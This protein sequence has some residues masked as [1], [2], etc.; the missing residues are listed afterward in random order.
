MKM[1]NM[2]GLSGNF[3]SVFQSLRRNG[4][5]LAIALGSLI[6]SPSAAMGQQVDFAIRQQFLSDPLTTEPRDPLLPNPPI[7]RPLS[8]LE[9]YELENQLDDLDQQSQ[10]LLAVGETN[11]AFV[12]WIRELRLRRALGEAQEMMAL[13]RVGALAW[14]NQRTRETQLI[15]LRLRQIQAE[16][17]AQ[18]PIEAQKLE[19]LADLFLVLRAQDSALEIYQ[20]LLSFA[21]Q[22]GDIAAQAA[23][24]TRIGEIHLAWFEFAAASETY[25]QLLAIARAEAEPVLEEEA[26]KRLISAFQQGEQPTQA[27]PYQQELIKFYQV[28]GT[29]DPIP[30]LEFALA[31]NYQADNRPD[32]A[33][34]HYQAAY[35]AA[36]RLQQYGYS[37]DVLWRLADLYRSLNRPEDTLY[38]LQ[39]LVEVEKQSYN[40]Y[41]IMNV[42][43]QI[44]QIYKGQGE[45]EQAIDALREGLILAR[46]LNYRQAYFEEQIQS[47]TQTT[48]AE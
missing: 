17:D 45:T 11:L 9:K 10:A 47:L 16:V 33:A 43:D 22:E 28:Q 48:P 1:C 6:I 27:I 24:L 39:L 29:D 42:F 35:A 13:E 23:R 46:Q 18:N 26:L 32:Q 37:S 12:Q 34:V 25:R 41:G 36:Q 8:P 7:R 38:V 15:T 31:Q 3:K 19:S 30:A 2:N 44:A 20:Q 40:A 21:V 4:I 14:S 5:L